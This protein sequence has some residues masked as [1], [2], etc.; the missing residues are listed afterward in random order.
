[1][2][3]RGGGVSRRTATMVLASAVLVA[4]SLT[5]CTPDITPLAEK[6]GDGTLRTDLVPLVT[7]VPRL[8]A[9]T[10]ALWMG[11]TLGSDRVPGPSTYWLDA[12]VALDDATLQEVSALP[13]LEVAGSPA[14]VKG[15]QASMPEGDLQRSD[16]L[17]RYFT[18]PPWYVQAWLAQES[19]QVV[20]LVQGGN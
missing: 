9:A 16:A 8:A 5:A 20:L 12:V 10:S 18:A 11:G 2:S 17:D 6:N 14:V 19:K 15:L 13:G 4:P 7:R 3:R 1:M